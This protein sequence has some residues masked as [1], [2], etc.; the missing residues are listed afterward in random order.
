M[1]RLVAL[2]A[3]ALTAVALP[4]ATPQAASD[5]VPVQDIRI[6]GTPTLYVQRPVSQRTYNAAWVLFRVRPHLH[7]PRQV[8]VELKGRRG[9][10]FGNTGSRD[11]VRA[12]I[13]QVARIVRPGA[14]YRVRFYGRR[15]VGGAQTLLRTF[16][17]AAHRHAVAPGRERAPRCR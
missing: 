4:P 9:R 16:T 17:L 1:P 2:A 8:V 7:E 6:V 13:I 15:S 14:K 11:C 10:S 12:T 5:R 3:I